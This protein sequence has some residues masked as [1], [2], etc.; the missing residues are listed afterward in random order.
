MLEITQE[1]GIVRMVEPGVLREVLDVR[2]SHIFFAQPIYNP[3]QAVNIVLQAPEV[4]EF[5]KT[6]GY[7]WPPRMVAATGITGNFDPP[8]DLPHVSGTMDNVTV[9]EA[10]DRILK[11]FP[12]MC[13]YENCLQTT[14]KARD[15]YIGFFSLGKLG[16]IPVVVH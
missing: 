8:P 16:S 1:G 11:T 15:I 13:V 2:I 12:G 5:M 3:I 14:D 9:S 4:E 6:R 10:L 7:S